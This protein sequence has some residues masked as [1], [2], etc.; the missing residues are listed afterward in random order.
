MFKMDKVGASVLES[1]HVTDWMLQG[2]TSG[3]TV[4]TSQLVSIYFLQYS[5]INLSF[6]RL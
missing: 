3:L 6:D 1:L 4:L 2:G 5:F